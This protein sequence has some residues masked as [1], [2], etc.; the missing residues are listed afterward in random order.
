[1]LAFATGVKDYSPTTL[2]SI[3]LI[4]GEQ[5]YDVQVLTQMCAIPAKLNKLQMLRSTYILLQEQIV[6]SPSTEASQ[7]AAA[8]ITLLTSPSPASSMHIWTAPAS[9]ALSD[10]GPVPA[11]VWGRSPELGVGWRCVS[12]ASAVTEV[13]LRRLENNPDMLHR[14]VVAVLTVEATPE[15]V[16]SS[17][18]QLDV[19]FCGLLGLHEWQ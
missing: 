7:A 12:D 5:P 19:L 9:D 14:R 10:A 1:M 4:H 11:K 13:H 18:H 3:S 2:N 17:H 16:S 15:E 6:S 8:E